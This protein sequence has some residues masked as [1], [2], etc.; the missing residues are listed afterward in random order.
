MP[1]SKKKGPGLQVFMR[2][3]NVIEDLRNAVQHLN[4]EIEG[5][6]DR[7]QP[8]W[9]SLSWFAFLD[10]ANY[11]GASCSLIAGT[12]FAEAQG[13][14]MM[15]PEGEVD[16]PVDLIELSAHGHS[17]DLSDAMRRVAHLIANM[18][19]ELEK[20]FSGYSVAGGDLLVFV[21]LQ[22]GDAKPEES[23]SP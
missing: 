5:L 8:V 3:T 22:F 2:H 21:G 9:G 23:A 1:G 12:L 18:E 17:V 4:H 11:F 20:Q 19:K 10:P 13:A 15:M 16:L 14:R 7:N 6:V